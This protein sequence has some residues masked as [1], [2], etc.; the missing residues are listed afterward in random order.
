MTI[1]S[2]A[3]KHSFLVSVTII[4]LI[5][6]AIIIG[7]KSNTAV[8]TEAPN[9]QKRVNLTNVAQFR[10]S[11]DFV[12]ANG[13]IVS[14]GQADL[15]SQISAPISLINGQIGDNVYSGQVIVELEN[16]DLLA[17]LQQSEASLALAQGQ[18]SSS[19][20]S[21]DST[22]SNAV[23]RVRDSYF[24]GYEAIITQIDPLLF[25]NDGN[26]GRLASI[27]IDS[28][29]NNRIIDVR[30]DLITA[31]RDWK[32]LS[33]NLNPDSTNEQITN[34]FKVS[35][36]NL[37]TIEKLLSDISQALNDA[38]KYSGTT[39]TTFL[40][41]WKT[42]VSTTRSSISG[43]NSSLIS[44]QSAFISAGTSYGSTALCKVPHS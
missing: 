1:F 31:L 42:V 44:A 41:T 10:Q 11:S 39:F 13:L 30:I 19:G 3:K 21:F 12:S 43:S 7:K 16:S 26:G 20:V 40:N 27:I 15:K 9:N 23:D 2:Y 36:K 24:K 8:I 25:N 14:K 4:I 6:L 18:Y 38:A 29:I 32:T 22:R 33:D 34:A 28:A 37:N 17:Q 35:L 5:I